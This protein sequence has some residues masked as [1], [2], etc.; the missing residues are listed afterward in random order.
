MGEAK[1]TVGAQQDDAAVSAKAGV[2]VVDRVGRCVLRRTA[3]CHAVYGPLAEHKLHDRFAPP[4]ERNSSRKIVGIAATTDQRGVTDP[5]GSFRQRASGGGA[6]S[7]VAELV[8]RHGAH[9]VVGVRGGRLC[10]FAVAAEGGVRAPGGF[11][12]LEGHKAVAL[13]GDD[14]FGVVDE[15][16]AMLIS[17]AFS[18]RANEIDVWAFVEN[19]TCGLN[20]ILQALHAGDPTR[21]EVFTIHQQGV[22]LHATVAGEK[23]AATGVEGIVV[24][25]HCDGSFDGIDGGPA[26]LERGPARSQCVGDAPLMRRNGVVGH[27]PCTAM[28]QKDGLRL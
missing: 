9:G 27:G 23:G 25:H 15:A 28:D 4:R 10:E 16:H 12:A 8:E 22:E 1:F 17:E 18:S 26:T 19:Q 14:E 6:G 11:L 7:K 21:A 2:Q 5:P 13:A 3:R 24:F 20:G